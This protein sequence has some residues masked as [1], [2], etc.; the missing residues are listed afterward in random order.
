MTVSSF[1]ICDLYF[2]YGRGG[3]RD[4]IGSKNGFQIYVQST[5]H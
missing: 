3:M 1:L 4:D 5:K 2:R